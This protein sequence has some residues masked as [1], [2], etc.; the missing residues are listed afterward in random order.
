MLNLLR[1]PE[2][3]LLR[4]SPSPRLSSKV[5]TKL[6]L[7]EAGIE[8]LPWPAS[9]PDLNPIENLWSILKERIARH[10][11]RPSTHEAMKEAILEEWDHI[12]EQELERIV[13]SLPNRIQQVIENHGGHT[14]W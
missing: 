10:L 9:S 6:K 12:S 3:V 1:Y 11:P 5:N 14:R 13:D 2:A 8:L 4:S 7:A